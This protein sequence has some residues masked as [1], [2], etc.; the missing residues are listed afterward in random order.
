MFTHRDVQREMF[1]MISLEFLILLALIVGFL[2]TRFW[3]LGILSF[4]GLGMM[5]MTV[6]FFRDPERTPPQ[7]GNWILAPADGKVVEIGK[8]VYPGTNKPAQKV[9][10]FLSVFNVHVNRI[11]VSGTI[12]RLDYHSGIFLPAF[13][14]EAS[15]ENEQTETWIQTEQGDVVVRQIAGIVARRIVRRLD[16]KEQVKSGDRFG[17]IRFG[18]RA[19]VFFPSSCRIRVAPGYRVRAGHTPIGEV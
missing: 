13:R 14:T 17:L 7:N 19:E 15:E 6:Y 10:I 2:M 8:T 16:L 3:I 9:A 18:S 5:A 11:P 1:Q 12:Q 4:V